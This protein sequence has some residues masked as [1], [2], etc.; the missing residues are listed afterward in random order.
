[1]LE[2]LLIAASVLVLTAVTLPA[3]RQAVISAGTVRLQIDFPFPAAVVQAPFVV[4]G[5]TFDREART[6]T[7]IDLVRVQFVPLDGGPTVSGDATL[8]IS[9]PDL[10]QAFGARAQLAGFQFLVRTPLVPGSYR[11]EVLVRRSGEQDWAAAAERFMTVSGTALTDLDSCLPGQVPRFTGRE[12]ACDSV[13]GTPGPP[14]PAGPAG[15]GGPA[16][17]IGPPGPAG[18]TGPAG[19]TLFTVRDADGRQVGESLDTNN[20]GMDAFVVVRVDGEP[21]LLFVNRNRIS[22]NRVVFETAD[23][24]GPAYIA[25]L[26]VQSQRFFPHTHVFGVSGAWRLYAPRLEE[27]EQVITA[28]SQSGNPGCAAVFPGPTVLRALPARLLTTLTFRAPFRVE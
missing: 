7:G 1:M 17:P 20:F 21:H 4:S 23:C 15:A 28:R 19:P 2:R 25:T 5:W 27:A 6:G 13:A 11:L 8:G 26:D 24:S 14:G 3:Q 22:S 16:G 9:R 12:W 18:A 10:V